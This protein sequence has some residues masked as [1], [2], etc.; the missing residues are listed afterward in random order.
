M[1][2][3]I[4]SKKKKKNYLLFETLESKRCAW[5]VATLQWDIFYP[6]DSIWIY[7]QHHHHHLNQLDP[8]KASDAQGC[9]HLQIIKSDVHVPEWEWSLI[10]CWWEDCMATT[11]WLPNNV[12]G[13]NKIFEVNSSNLL[14]CCLADLRFLTGK[15]LHN[16]DHQQSAW[17]YDRE[18]FTFPFEPLT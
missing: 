9:D 5:S 16:Q 4:S 2:K 6:I 13:N 12:H 7:Y 17:N 14:F 15:I 11:S 3:T 18:S 8:A 1:I 10:S